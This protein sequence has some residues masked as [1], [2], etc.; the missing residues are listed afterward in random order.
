MDTWALDCEAH[1]RMN[2]DYIGERT[3]GDA[4]IGAEG[5]WRILVVLRRQRRLIRR[6]ARV[7][8]T[9][10]KAPSKSIP[11]PLEVNT[12]SRTDRIPMTKDGTR[13]GLV[14]SQSLYNTPRPP[15]VN[16]V[17][18]LLS[19]PPKSKISIQSVDVICFSELLG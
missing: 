8:D 9:R 5:C 4:L 13:I 19:S 2:A 1:A 11:H 7:N 10:R 16:I 12:F 17:W 3:T 14:A 15:I 18:I 6:G